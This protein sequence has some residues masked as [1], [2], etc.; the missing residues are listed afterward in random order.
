MIFWTVAATS[1]LGMPYINAAARTF[2]LHNDLFACGELV[3]VVVCHVLL[4]HERG[5]VGLDEPRRAPQ[6]DEGG[7][8]RCERVALEDRGESS[9]SCELFDLPGPQNS[10]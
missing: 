9:W 10:P 1:Q 8:E 4:R 6:E 5:N 3:D 7:Q 2:P